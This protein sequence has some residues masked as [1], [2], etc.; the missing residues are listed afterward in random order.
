MMRV[1]FFLFVMVSFLSNAQ[2]SM[3]DFLLDA[4]N[5]PAIK[6]FANQN[7]FL[8]SKP[9]R[10]APIRQLQFRTES[11][12]LDPERQDYS[13]RLSPAN[14]W[15]MKRNNEYFK[16]YKEMLQLDRER[17]VKESLMAR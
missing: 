12:Q 1:F 10:L 15:E 17:L 3:E 11:N 4:L 9:F 16:S 6:S 5:E 8:D 7:T 13:L 2:V 14:P